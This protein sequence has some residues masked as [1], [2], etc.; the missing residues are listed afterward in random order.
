MDAKQIDPFEPAPPR[1]APAPLPPQSLASIPEPEIRDLVS[2][3]WEDL[4]EEAYTQEG[5]ANM[6]V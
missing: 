5:I 4:P 6:I 1:P 2:E 3:P